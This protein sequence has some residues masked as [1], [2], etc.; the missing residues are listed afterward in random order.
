MLEW[1]SSRKG[2][3]MFTRLER[4]QSILEV[5]TKGR[6]KSKPQTLCPALS[7]EV[8]SFS[9]WVLSV[10]SSAGRT[11]PTIESGCFSWKL[12]DTRFLLTA[13]FWSHVCQATLWLPVDLPHKDNTPV[14][15]TLSISEPHHIDF[16]WKTTKVTFF[17]FLA[18]NCIGLCAQRCSSTLNF[19]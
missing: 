15:L 3:G 5:L 18:S 2:V 4:N 19:I 10:S 13:F 8:Q 9:Q 6:N 7:W 17:L 14:P 16:S 1:G 12:L 11:T